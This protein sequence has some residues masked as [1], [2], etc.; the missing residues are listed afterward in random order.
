MV[1]MK[2]VL[3]WTG[4]LFKSV[5]CRVAS[6][7]ERSKAIDHGLFDILLHFCVHMSVCRPIMQASHTVLAI[8]WALFAAA[9]PSSPQNIETSLQALLHFPCPRLSFQPMLTNLGQSVIFLMSVI[10]V[11]WPRPLPP[12]PQGSAYLA[13]CTTEVTM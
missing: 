4:C 3:E 12:L 7:R 5:N 13:Q 2:S 1:G 10:E 9:H 6:I 11:V 8:G